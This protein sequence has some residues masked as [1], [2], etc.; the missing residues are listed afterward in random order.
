MER[1]MVI[2]GELLVEGEHQLGSGVYREGNSVYASTLGLL[3]EKSGYVRVIPITGKYIPTVEDFVIGKVEE[4]QFSNWY[5][6]IN[7]AYTG[8]LN[9]KDYFR[10]VDPRETDL[11]TILAPGDVIY[12]KVREITH[13]KKVYITMTERRAQV[14]KKGRLI[15]MAP[16]KV[17]RLIGK[18]SSMISMITDESK[19]KI[20]VGQNGWIWMDGKPAMVDLVVRAIRRIEEEAHKSGLT[21]TIKKMII[22]ERESI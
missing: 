4:S 15:D 16:V 19:C 17:P 1:R 6:D 3:D 12:A 14:L 9:A 11:N 10:D 22:E 8:A 20:I 18:K 21:D 2:P 7:S 5:V 13:S